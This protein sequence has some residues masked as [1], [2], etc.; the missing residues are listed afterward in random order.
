MLGSTKI[1]NNVNIGQICKY[2]FWYVHTS[3]VVKFEN[4]LARVRAHTHTNIHE[5]T[6]ARA[7]AYRN[8]IVKS[9]EKEKTLVYSS[10]IRLPGH[11]ISTPLLY[12]VTTHL[13]TLYRLISIDFSKRQTRSKEV[14]QV[15]VVARWSYPCVASNRRRRDNEWCAKIAMFLVQKWQSISRKHR[16]CTLI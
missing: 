8:T 1:L 14:R 12:V 15:L 2:D 11:V 3:W 10:S 13:Y 5:Y 16:N 4:E 7:R 6:R 9:L